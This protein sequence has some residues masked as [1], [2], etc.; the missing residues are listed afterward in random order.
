MEPLTLPDGHL[1]PCMLLFL[2]WLLLEWRNGVTNAD[3]AAAA[4][5]NE[6]GNAVLESPEHLE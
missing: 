4:T 6:C 1:S 3:C 2:E 5:R